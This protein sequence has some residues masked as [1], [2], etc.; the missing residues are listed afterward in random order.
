M[1]MY[2][3]PPIPFIEANPRKHKVALSHAHSRVNFGRTRSWKDR[4]RSARA[5]QAYF[6]ITMMLCLLPTVI[7]YFWS[8]MDTHSF[9]NSVDHTYDDLEERRGEEGSPLVT[10]HVP[11]L[12]G[13]AFDNDRD[14]DAASEDEQDSFLDSYSASVS[15]S[16]SSD[17]GGY[18]TERLPVS[19]HWFRCFSLRL[20]DNPALMASLSRPQTQFRAVF[21]LD[22]WFTE[23]D[24]RFGTTRLKFLLECLHDLSNQLEALGLRLYIAQG[25]TTAVLASLCQEWGVTYLSYQKSQEP[26]SKVE[27]RTMH[28]MASMMN[29]EVEEFHN[30]TLYSP[31]DLLQINEGKPVLTFKD[32]RTLLSKLKPPPAP[33]PGPSLKQRYIEDSSPMFVAQKFQIPSLASLGC[34][35]VQLG[36]GPWVGGESEVLKR[37]DTYCATRSKPFNRPVD[38]LFDKTSLSPYVRFGCLSVRHFWHYVR[39]LAATDKS[40]LMLVQDVSSKLLQRE[41]YFLV[42]SQVPNFDTDKQNPLCIQLPWDYDAELLRRWKAGMTGYPWIDAAIRQMLKEGW[43]HHLLR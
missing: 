21:V 17:S 5:V 38:C 1:Q 10:F 43:I 31:D 11:L 3:M 20:H 33:I 8:K 42:S 27:E 16:P 26:R 15:S 30:H 24:C 40:K 2:S 22:P 23:S 37:L 34:D 9:C 35:D 25:Q 28:E 36:T 18:L 32:F 13:V 19:L 12:T 6:L 14:Y 39:K 41:F 4:W 29:I 7:H